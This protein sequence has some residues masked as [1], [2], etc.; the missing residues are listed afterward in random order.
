LRNDRRSQTERI[1]PRLI[2]A[3]P[4]DDRF[5]ERSFTRLDRAYADARYSPANDITGE[6]LALLADRVKA[7]QD[8]VAAICAEHL[9]DAGSSTA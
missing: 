7:L 4:R 2:A 9:A 8:G 6:E 1:A 5:A 3:R